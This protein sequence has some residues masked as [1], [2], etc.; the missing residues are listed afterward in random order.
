M[1][2]L[3]GESYKKNTAARKNNKQDQRQDLVAIDARGSK[4]TETEIYAQV[5]PRNPK[6]AGERRTAV[7][8]FAPQHKYPRHNSKGYCHDQ[9]QPGERRTDPA[10]H[11]RRTNARQPLAITKP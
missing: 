4:D 6:T 1:V 9:R 10:L 8:Y 7:A 2:G 3:F 11:R 5:D